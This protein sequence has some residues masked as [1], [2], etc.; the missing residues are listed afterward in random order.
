MKIDLT[1]AIKLR[2]ITKSLSE[3]DIEKLYFYQDEKTSR[4]ILSLHR[5]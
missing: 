1:K 5:Q 2:P 3:E 4:F